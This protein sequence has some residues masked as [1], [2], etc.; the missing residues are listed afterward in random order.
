MPAAWVG[1]LTDEDPIDKAAFDQAVGLVMNGQYQQASRQFSSLLTRLETALTAAKHRQPAANPAEASQ[2]P[3]TAPVVGAARATVRMAGESMFWIAYC[4]E[5][6]DQ[7]G[8]AAIL[9][10]KVLANY[11]NTP[12]ASQAAKRL[13]LLTGG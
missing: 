10:N 5:K 3:T 12:A 2:Q 9:Y 11:P 6:Q 1:L 4:A 7:A 8:Q 13:N